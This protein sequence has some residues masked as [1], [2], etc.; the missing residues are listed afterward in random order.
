M[1]KPSYLTHSYYVSTLHTG[2]ICGILSFSGTDN[3]V[4]AMHSTVRF[5]SVEF[6]CCRGT[7]RMLFHVLVLQEVKHTHWAAPRVMEERRHVVVGTVIVYCNVAHVHGIT[8]NT[9]PVRTVFH[10][11]RGLLLYVTFGRCDQSS[12]RE[13]ERL[14]SKRFGVPHRCIPPTPQNHISFICPSH[15]IIL[16]TFIS[17]THITSEDN[18]QSDRH[19]NLT[20]SFP[21]YLMLCVE[22]NTCI[23]LNIRQC[24][25]DFILSR[26]ILPCCQKNSFV[27]LSIFS[28]ENIHW[29]LASKVEYINVIFNGNLHK[30]KVSAN[31]NVLLNTQQQQ[32]LKWQ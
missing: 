20:S 9:Y 25:L 23:A 14:F 10:S 24:V 16:I 1:T 2:I 18:P 4:W 7:K 19:T 8:Y 17:F 13:S 27:H 21:N 3:A 26:N 5:F 28:K 11:H 31:I 32:K 29:N 6:P 15:Y 30:K 22:D 12:M